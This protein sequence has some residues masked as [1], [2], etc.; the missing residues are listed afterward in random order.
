MIP[1]AALL[2]LLLL[3]VGWLVVAAT[4]RSEQGQRDAR[5]RGHAPCVPP[6]NWADEDDL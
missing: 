6:Y 4:H 3:A 2:L 5:G 1:P